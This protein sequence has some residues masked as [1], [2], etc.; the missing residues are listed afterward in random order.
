M[1]TIQVS[2][3]VRPL[4]SRELSQGHESCWTRNGNTL[5][6]KESKVAFSFDS[7]FDKDNDYN[8]YDKTT[9]QLIS[10]VMNGFNATIIAYGQTSSGKTHTMMG[11]YE[12]M[13]IIPMAIKDI[14]T[15]INNVLYISN[16]R[17]QTVN[18]YCV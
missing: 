13:G 16:G 11:D 12:N 6:H 17:I 9:G 1:N 18:I 15:I 4:N 5:S 3:R 8:L 2:V 10:S 14:F 7:V